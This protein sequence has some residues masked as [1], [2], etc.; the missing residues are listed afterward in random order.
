MSGR[1][2]CVALSDCNVNEYWV[3]S[4]LSVDLLSLI[5]GIELKHNSIIFARSYSPATSGV[6]PSLS[7]R[8]VYL[9]L[10]PFAHVALLSD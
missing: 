1:Q 9:V 3:C 5:F 7:L 8:E 6:M 10:L 2:E 4:A